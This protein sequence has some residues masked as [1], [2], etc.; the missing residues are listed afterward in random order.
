MNIYIAH[1]KDFDFKKELYEP[2]KKSS[3]SEDNLFIFPHERE[4]GF[5]DS[6]KFIKDDC[7]LIIAETSYP[8]TGL[9]IELGWANIYNIPIVCF[10][11][12][13]SKISKSLQVVTDYFF[14]Y[15]T[16]DDLIEKI[17]NFLETKF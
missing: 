5:F 4:D 15:S 10:Y 14:E 12:K 11:K 6:K 2:I 8:S 1:S 3:L 7:D 9:G 17:N 16:E 13:G